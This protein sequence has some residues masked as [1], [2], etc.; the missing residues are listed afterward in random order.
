MVVSQKAMRRI[1]RDKTELQKNPLHSEGIY[2]LHDPNDLKVTRACIIGPE[3]TPYE[4]GFY[5]FNIT[6]P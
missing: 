1:H 4:N 6:F 5:F 3:G 2:V